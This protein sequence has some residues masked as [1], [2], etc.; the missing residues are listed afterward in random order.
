M[1][2]VE[3][4][5]K[6]ENLIKKFKTIKTATRIK[7]SKKCEENKE[8]LVDAALTAQNTNKI[9][10]TTHPNKSYKLWEKSFFILFL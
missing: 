7:E 5:G 1:S 8:P 4:G 3:K 2:E 6:R 9:N 10:K